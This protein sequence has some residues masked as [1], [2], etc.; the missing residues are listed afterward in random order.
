[1]LASPE[2]MQAPLQ[3][4]VAAARLADPK[5]EQL[6]AMF[7]EI[8]RDVLEAFLASHQGDVE[9]AVAAILDVP[10]DAPTT[11]QDLDEVVA[12]A[13]QQ[14]MDAEVARGV[15]QQMNAEEEARRAQDPTVRAAAAVEKAG[16]MAKSLLQ[17]A[18]R[19]LSARSRGT[20]HSVRL[21]DAPMDSSGVSPSFDFT[22]ISLPAYAPPPAQ[23]QPLPDALPDISDAV[24]ISAFTPDVAPAGADPSARYSARLDRARSAN[25]LRARQASSAGGESPAAPSPPAAPHVPEGQLI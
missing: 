6:K 12:R 18:V 3:A 1:M 4:G 11:Q 23:A 22:P 2:F 8:D 17:R 9:R 5:V 13:L 19:P 24:P 14:E 10:A 25:Q 7:P 21:L 15:Q 20:T 16:T